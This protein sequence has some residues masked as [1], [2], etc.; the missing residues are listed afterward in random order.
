VVSCGPGAV[1]SV[2]RGIQPG[3]HSD[4]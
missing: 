3:P 2:V 1:C 4:V